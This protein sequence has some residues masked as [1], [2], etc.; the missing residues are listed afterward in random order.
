MNEY[1][2]E[3]A[4]QIKPSPTLAAADKAKKLKAAGKNI[5]N[6]TVGQPNFPAPEFVKQA[7]ISAIENDHH[8]YTPVDG[9]PELKTAIINKLKRDNN[10]SYTADQII[11]SSGV[12]HCLFNLTQSVLGPGDEAIVLAPYWVSYSSMVSLAGATPIEI[13]AGI[14]Q[15]FKVT[16]TQLEQAITEKTKLVFINSP[17]NPSGAVY[18]LAE[19]KAIAE[20]LIKHPNIL[21]VSDDIYEYIVWK[22]GGFCNILNAAPELKDRTIVMNGV[23]KAHCMAGWRIGFAACHPTLMKAMKKIQSQSTTC[24]TSIA[25]HAAIAAFDA[26]ADDFF[27]PMLIEYKARHDWVINALNELPHVSAIP[28]KGT[29]YA[30]FDARELIKALNLKDDIALTDYFLEEINIAMVPGSAFG[31]TGY[32]RLSFATS[33]D[34]LKEAFDRLKNKLPVV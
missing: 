27:Q 31:S 5:I 13:Q 10:L 2:S 28:S 6:L 12:K 34:Q 3:R 23:A 21:I 11:V 20:V 29:F 32:M 14:E 9:I 8:G 1:L 26:S 17:S 18:S 16:P 15:N 30:F 4:L 24:A 25:Q 7:G 19:L 33:M 22:Q